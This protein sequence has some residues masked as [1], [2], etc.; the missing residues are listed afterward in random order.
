MGITSPK[1]PAPAPTRLRRI[2]AKICTKDEEL[3]YCC[4][5][6]IESEHEV[7]LS[8][9][10]YRLVRSEYGNPDKYKQADEPR[11]DRQ[12]KFVRIFSWM[13]FALTAINALSF[14]LHDSNPV[15]RSDAWYFLD[16]FLRKIL[17][18]KLGLAD[19]FVKRNGADHA[20]PMFKLILLLE[21]RY[22]D[23]DFTVE[24]V[25]GL[26]GAVMCS[27]LFHHFVM[28]CRRQNQS[29]I[30]RY[31]AWSAICAV[32]FSLNAMEIWTWP[33]VTI[34]YLTFIPMLLF[35]W[36]MWSAWQS[37]R[38]TLLIGATIL[39][40]VTDDDSAIIAVISALLAT[41]IVATF[42]HTQ[43]N[44]HLWKGTFA[45]VVTMV[46][47]RIA[48]SYAPHVGGAPAPAIS[49]NV[50]ILLQ[51]LNRGEI[52]K[53]IT[54]PLTLSVMAGPPF[55]AY[56]QSIWPW[57]ETM[58][59]I[60][61]LSAHCWFWWRAMQNGHNLATFIAVC[62]MIL[63]YGWLA[64]ILTFR[65]PLYGLDYL[66]QGRYIRLYQFNIIALLLM[67]AG[68]NGDIH[69]Q[70]ACHNIKTWV[71]A[72]AC[73]LLIA[74]QIP[75]SRLAWSSSKALHSYY[76]QMALQIQQ[77]T[78]NPDQTTNCLPET[79]VCKAA[80]W[81]RRELTQILLTHHLNIFS[82]RVQQWHPYLPE[83]PNQDNTARQETR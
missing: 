36:A 6:P 17:D 77:L 33:L 59:A 2:R 30:F 63:S 20:Q 75:L 45:V 69:P 1:G 10:I 26:C 28:R 60:T 7:T 24:A 9:R 31:L 22:F 68:K 72:L 42:D 73:V 37:Q 41:L 43:R 52:W 16:V 48:Y 12:L 3:G 79:V 15:I 34:E 54:T 38:Y 82:K 61:M 14:V 19:F 57:I 70:N 80:D 25:A 53:W 35:M 5:C 66:H 11:L 44:K 8:A 65:V 39:L 78:S 32:L 64:G 27:M 56:L 21:L 50:H 47:V 46:A 58:V 4:Q 29:D 83:L 74:L 67:L 18:G 81:Q 71:P 51:Q 23:L 55:P 62:L 76:Q 49:S 40:C 13:V